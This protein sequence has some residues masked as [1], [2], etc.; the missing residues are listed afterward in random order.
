MKIDRSFVTVQSEA[1]RD[2][3]RSL[4]DQAAP[5]LGAIDIVVTTVG[6]DMAVLVEALRAYAD[7]TFE[8]LGR[9]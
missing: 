5:T 9:A 3:L 2:V 7:E 1:D 8:A 4:A 6:P